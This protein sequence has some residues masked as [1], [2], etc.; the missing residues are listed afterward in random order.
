MR[1]QDPWLLW[2]I[3]A[4]CVATGMAGWVLIVRDNVRRLVAV[5]RR[6]QAT[7]ALIEKIRGR[8]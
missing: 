6:R 3:V 7:R 5:H 4:A 1:T 2:I 8:K